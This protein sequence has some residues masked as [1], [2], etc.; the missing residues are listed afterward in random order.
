MRVIV[1][2]FIALSVYL[3]WGPLPVIRHPRAVKQFRVK[4]TQLVKSLRKTPRLSPMAFL[5]T[6]HS[7]LMAGLLVDDALGR[8]C[9]TLPSHCITNTSEALSANGDI[10]T[11]LEADAQRTNLEV[12]ADVALIY[13]VCARTGAPMTDSLMRLINSVRDQQ[14]RQRTLV[15]ETAST[16]ATA[17]V[18]AALPI[19]GILMGLGLGLNPL[20]WFLHSALGALCLASGVGLEVLGWLWVRLLMRRASTPA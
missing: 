2:W 5:W 12:L 19:L 7:E 14:R 13:R 17:V 9:A 18:L 11:A 1:G 8:A 3:A 4:M 20:T 16:K 10:A 6:L 15:Q